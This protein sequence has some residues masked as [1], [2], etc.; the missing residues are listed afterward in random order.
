MR[1]RGSSS[2]APTASPVIAASATSARRGEASRTSSPSCCP[3]R[4]LGTGLASTASAISSAARARRHRATTTSSPAGSPRHWSPSVP[5]PPTCMPPASPATAPGAFGST[6]RRESCASQTTASSSPTGSSSSRQSS[7]SPTGLLSG[8]RRARSCSIISLPGPRSGR[9][10]QAHP[11][12]P[13]RLRR[14]LRGRLP[15]RQ[16]QAL[17]R[18]GIHECPSG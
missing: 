2:T 8:R 3:V 9:Q 1:A 15:G 6:M 13:G 17:A 7:S 14:L 18:G 11:R 16:A 12:W 10:R 5:A 4:S